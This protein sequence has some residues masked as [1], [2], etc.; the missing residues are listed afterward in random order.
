MKTEQRRHPRYRIRDAAFHV[1]SH[2]TQISGRLVNIGKGGLAFQFTPGNGKTTACRAIDI[3]GPGADRFYLAGIRCRRIYDIC[4]LAEDQTFTG[5]STRLCGL[6][7][8]DLTAEQTRKLASLID[9]YGI[10][11]HTIP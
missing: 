2:G 5:A 6:Q 9:R 3:L 1:F 8:I 4:A 10:E 7:F 11:L